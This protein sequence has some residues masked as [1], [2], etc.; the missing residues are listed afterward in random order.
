M[1]HAA[2]LLVLGT[3]P[4]GERSLV[5]HSLSPQL[6]RRGFLAD[7]SKGRTLFLPL[8]LLDAEVVENPRSDLWRLRAVTPVHALGGIRS[9]LYKNTVALF[10][11]EVLFRVL[12]D[13]APVEEGLF[14]W[15]ERSVRTLDAI[16]SDFANFHLRFLLELCAQLGFTPGAESLAPFAGAHL[17]QLTALQEAPFP[18]A[19]TL[20]LSGRMRGELARI[21]LNYLSFHAE[22]PLNIRSLDV[23]SEVFACK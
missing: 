5:V 8:S 9:N 16:E 2:S 15:C 13:G 20:P 14:A 1:I 21:L 4:T 7:A 11:S 17:S 22:L 3:T 18:Q 6:G 19:M 10:L 23:L 12:R